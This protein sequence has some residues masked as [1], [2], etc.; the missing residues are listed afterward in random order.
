MSV[1]KF[2]T[3]DFEP[4]IPVTAPE[5]QIALARLAYEDAHPEHRGI[6]TDIALMEWTRGVEANYAER[7]RTYVEQHPHK[8]I[9]LND[10]TELV[11][12]LKELTQN[13]T[14]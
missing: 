6:E 2:R 10:P 7:Y 14:H 13:S 9:D 11:Q 8:R 12:V 1:E 3:P 5:V 4:G